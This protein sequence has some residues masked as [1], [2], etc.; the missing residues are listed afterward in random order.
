[1]AE[2]SVRRIRPTSRGLL[3]SA[4]AA[5]SAGRWSWRVRPP[6]PTPVRRSPAF[7]GHR[8]RACRAGAVAGQVAGRPVADAVRSGSGCLG[9]NARTVAQ[10]A[11]SV[12]QGRAGRA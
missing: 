10:E 6:P 1:P 12:R 2:S 4:G 9:R 11:P 7:S 5:G 8:A 3:H